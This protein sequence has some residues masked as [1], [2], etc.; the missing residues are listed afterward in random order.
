MVSYCMSIQSRPSVLVITLSS[1]SILH[2]AST[3]VSLQHTEF[4][5]TLGFLQLLVLCLTCFSTPD[6]CW[7]G[8]SPNISSLEGPF[9]EMTTLHPV[10]PVT[11]SYL[12]YF[13]WSEIISFFKLIIWLLPQES[14]LWR[15]W[16]C[17]PCS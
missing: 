11:L 3:T 6:L 15:V 8:L 5:L 14:K 4:I 12:F 17:L 16:S 10:I 9:W 1:L 7:A 2:Q 13:L